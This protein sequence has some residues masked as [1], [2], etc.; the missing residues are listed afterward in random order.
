M[1][2]SPAP[3]PLF[4]SRTAQLPSSGLAEVFVLAARPDAVDLA[5]GTPGSPETSAD[6]LEEAA[7]ALRSGRNQYEHPSGNLEL[8]RRIAEMLSADTDP[9]TELTVTAGATE[10]LYVALLSTVD[11]GDE[12]ILFDPGFDQF[13]GT[14]ALVGARPR[15]VPLHAPEWRHDPAELAAAFGPRTRAIVL[16]TP[17]NPTGRVLTRQELAE[18]GELCERWNVTAISDE[19]YGAFVF[20]GHRHVSVADVPGLAERSV[21]VGSLSKSHAVSGWR[22]GF[23][24]ADRARTEV[25]QRVHQLTTLGTSAPLQVAAGQALGSVDL[26]DAAAEMAVRRDLAQRIFSRL[27]MKFAPAE[28]GCYLFADIGPL[29]E[30]G[31]GSAAYVRSLFDA[32]RVLLAPGT[33]FFAEPGR[34]ERYVRVA[35]NKP[36]ETLRAAER[37]LLDV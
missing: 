27:G 15:Y 6:L 1:T 37:R 4:S 11:P 17:A 19:V 33:A 28:G 12:V 2:H 23:L 32:T 5:I 26:A 25:F 30:E 16:N 7:R 9:V 3:R 20:D 10:A 31:Q 13:A 34:G 35:F 36:L 18:I 8:R 21:V 29:V 24:R 22:V 14:V